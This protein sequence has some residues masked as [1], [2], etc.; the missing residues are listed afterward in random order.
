[1]VAFH[2]VV[3]V[4]RCLMLNTRLFDLRSA[5]PDRKNIAVLRRDIR[6]GSVFREH[7]ATAVGV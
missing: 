4:L 7:V 2:A 5:Q 6:E 3:E 1:M